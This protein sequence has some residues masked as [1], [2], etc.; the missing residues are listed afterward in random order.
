MN[1]EQA[2]GMG[3]TALSLAAALV[4][5]DGWLWRLS[6]IHLGCIAL[7]LLTF[8]L[9][10]RKNGERGKGLVRSRL[11]VKLG[12][13]IAA[14]AA[15]LADSMLRMILLRLPMELPFEYTTLLCP[16]VMVWYILTELGS[17]LLEV[18]RLGT[19][20]P[21]FLTRAFA[22]LASQA[23]DIGNQGSA[24]VTL[25]PSGAPGPVSGQPSGAAAPSDR[26]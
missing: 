8:T 21:P 17:T 23:S 6:L 3:K 24:S 9:A 5:F 11:W 7:D 18:A 2:G 15:A 14:M 1:T 20:V 13:I 12:G 16:V 10:C 22:N 25:D 26:T 4:P 19:V